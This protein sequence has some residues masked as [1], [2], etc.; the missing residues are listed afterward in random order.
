MQRAKVVQVRDQDLKETIS[1]VKRDGYRIAMVRAHDSS[2]LEAI[3][4]RVMTDL[5]LT[6][7]DRI[8]LLGEIERMATR[9]G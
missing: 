2:A 3:E 5:Q 9:V 6:S 7:D 1:S 4:Q 8:Q